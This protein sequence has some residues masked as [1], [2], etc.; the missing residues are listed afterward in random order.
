MAL[1]SYTPLEPGHIRLL[2][3]FAAEDGELCASIQHVA[4]DREDPIVYSALS[5]VWGTAGSTV[6]LRCDG[7]IL[8]ITSTLAEALRQVITLGDQKAL[9]VDQICI[10]QHDLHERSQQVG[11]MN[12]IFK[13]ARR[14]IA[15]LG[16]STASTPLA[17]DLIT[18]VGT[19]ARNMSG[20][21]FLWDYEQY[22]PES[23]KT[24]EKLSVEA[25]EKLGIS[26]SD[27]ESWDAFS[28]FYDRS[29]YERVWIVQEML[30]S[31]NALIVCGNHSISWDLVKGAASWYHYKAGA[32]SERHRRSVD[33][34]SL[35]TAMELSW[36]GR[37]M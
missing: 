9:W 36:N 26:F 35:T 8:H 2:S 4:F 33:G 1:Y 16:P 19:I 22:H 32:I 31:R 23:L 5:Y 17:I 13:C 34:I 30:P 29:W 15:Y 27:T 6:P 3:L 25:T 10:N 37:C 11:K 12:A 28:E 18:R 14:V 21:V 24:Y 7:A 20:D